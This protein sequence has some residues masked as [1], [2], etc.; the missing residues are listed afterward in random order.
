MSE[1]GNSLSLDKNTTYMEDPLHGSKQIPHLIK[2]LIE[3][4]DKMKFIHLH[5]IDEL[6]QIKLKYPRQDIYLIEKI[7]EI[8]NVVRC[9][10][11]KEPYKG[12]HS[13]DK[14]ICT[15]CIEENNY[16]CKSCNK[17]LSDEMVRKYCKKSLSCIKCRGKV[18]SQCGHYCESCILLYPLSFYKSCITCYNYFKEQT[19]KSVKC[20]KCRQS[21]T[22]LNM[23]EFCKKHFLCDKCS[24]VQ[25]ETGECAC[26]ITLSI[27]KIEFIYEKTHFLCA[28]C[29][30]YYPRS[31]LNESR[32]CYNN[33]CEICM[34]LSCHHCNS[35]SI[36]THI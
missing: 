23:F 27:E 8:L 34:E 36:P 16:Q 20:E 2:W 12:K 4:F 35:P 29:N 33:F 14:F 7:D 1:E 11:H 26:G 21:C 18:S 9:E 31:Q 10:T 30:F 3:S 24:M 5:G 28:N 13:C 19:G 25:I 22:V 32:C 15:K 6:D 17:K